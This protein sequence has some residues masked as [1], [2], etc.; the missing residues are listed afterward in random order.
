MTR[1]TS[2]RE[3]ARCLGLSHTAIQKAERAGRIGRDADGSW[4]LEKVR[5]DLAPA[6]AP[7]RFPL[8]AK[9]GNA[10]VPPSYVPSL[11]ADIVGPA[12]AIHAELE[13]ARLTLEKAARRIAALYP[14]ILRLERA[15]D[16]AIAAQE[17]EPP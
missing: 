8:A 17:R 9:A 16:A 12:R 3:V 6:T 14:E 10:P 13:K 11:P 4:D 2:T 15:R 1:I 7:R 5:R